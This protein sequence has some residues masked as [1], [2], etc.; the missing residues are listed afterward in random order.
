MAVRYY[1]EFTGSSRK[2]PENLQVKGKIPQ[3]NT[4]VLTTDKNIRQQLHPARRYKRPLIDFRAAEHLCGEPGNKIY[5]IVWQQVHFVL[6]GFVFFIKSGCKSL[7]RIR[8][9]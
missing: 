4:I 7:F 1:F 3:R 9:R 6:R 5:L 8:V 2:G